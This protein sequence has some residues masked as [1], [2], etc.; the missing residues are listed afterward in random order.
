MPPDFVVS[1]AGEAAGAQ[2]MQQFVGLVGVVVGVDWIQKLQI[3]QALPG[4]GFARKDS[5]EFGEASLAGR[6]RL[7]Q[8]GEPVLWVRTLAACVLG[9]SARCH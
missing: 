7:P 6:R 9:A 5:L 1:V 8:N 3:D 2:T 4:H